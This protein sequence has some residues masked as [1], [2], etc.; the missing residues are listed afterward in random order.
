VAADY[1]ISADFS[2]EAVKW[3]ESRYELDIVARRGGLLVFVEVKASTGGSFG[4][5]ELRVNLNKQKRI[6]AAALEYLSRLEYQPDEIRFDVIGIIWRK[7]EKPG[8]N[9][10]ESAF[11]VE[12]F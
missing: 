3:R 11:I 9:H 5:P 1:L 4:P 10:I 6:A 2:I 8:I 12:D 7:G